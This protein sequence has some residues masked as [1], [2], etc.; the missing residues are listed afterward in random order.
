MKTILVPT[1]FSD[2]A[3]NA[4]KYALEMAGSDKE[5][6]LM[7]AYH[8]PNAGTGGML[9]SI[10]DM[11]KKE[12]QKDM[13]AL[14]KGIKK[15]F[16]ESLNLRGES[17]HGELLEAIE[18][19]TKNQEIDIVV[20]GTQ[21][22]SGLKQALIGSNTEKAIRE[23]KVPVIAV[24]EK[25]KYDGYDDIVFATDMKEIKDANIMESMLTI[26]KKFQ[27]KIYILYV[28][29]EGTEPNIDEDVARLNLDSYFEGIDH[30]Y[31]VV[32]NDDIEEGINGF[33]KE[34][35]AD[36]L[37]MIPRKV[38][39]FDRLFKKSITKQCVYHTKVPLLAIHD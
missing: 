32:F 35:N 14:I 25:G 27:A 5:F 12:S 23:A 2:N 13:K 38:S 29:K 20:M 11:L 24:P 16:G 17:I 30:S 4:F 33:I 6:V 3:L 8:S 31:H 26:A 37:S 18:Y 15:Q 1:D 39:F 19:I 7:N 9:V 21:G 34:V 10:T 28:I 36:L 22:A